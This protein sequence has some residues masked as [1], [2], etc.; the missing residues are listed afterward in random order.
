MLDRS[1]LHVIEIDDIEKIFQKLDL[2]LEKI[3]Q[4]E[5]DPIEVLMKKIGY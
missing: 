1:R 2:G 4:K 5:A 3:L